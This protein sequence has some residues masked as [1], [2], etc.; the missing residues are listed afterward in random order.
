MFQTLLSLALLFA[1]VYVCFGATLFVNQSRFI[2]FPDPTIFSTPEKL[3]LKYRSVTFATADNVNLDAW[4]IPAA[5]AKGVILFCHG[6]AGNISHRLETIDIFH[7]LGYST[8]IFDYRGY[9][10]SEGTPSEA[11]TYLDV[12]AAWDYLVSREK[13][14]PSQII[15]FGRSLGGAI[16]ARLCSRKEPRACIL[17]STFTSAKDMAA[18][19]Y[20]F[21]PGR[22]LCR[23]QYNT[24]T[25]VSKIRC[26]LLI[27]HSPDDDIVP[28]SHGRRLFAAAHAPK[29]FL[30]ISGNH[31][32]GFL[33]SAVR[34][35][36]GLEDF[37]DKIGTEK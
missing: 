25:A 33:L 1:A 30:Q 3:G 37:L 7:R 34:Y 14:T 9:G 27:I 22:L 13:I 28:F 24:E 32:A 18:A 5:E 17:E 4:F 29:T 26:P 23:F 16:A 2:Y 10:K 36:N 35:K 11:G 19:M 20:P 15:V 31:N 6:N 21:F 8:F 12:E